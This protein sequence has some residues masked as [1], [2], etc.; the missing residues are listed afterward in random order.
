M[1]P[2]HQSGCISDKR[3]QVHLK[4]LESK[5]YLRAAAFGSQSV[6]LHDSPE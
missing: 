2:S 1:P 6:L 3:M 4:I 5:Y